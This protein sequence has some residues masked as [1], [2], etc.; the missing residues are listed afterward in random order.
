[1][2]EHVVFYIVLV[3]CYN[4]LNGQEKVKNTQKISKLKRTNGT[5]AIVANVMLKREALEGPW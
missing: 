5:F 3:A 4:T 2:V 1:M